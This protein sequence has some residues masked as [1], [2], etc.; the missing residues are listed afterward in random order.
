M[1]HHPQLYATRRNGCWSTCSCGWHSVILYTSVTGAHIAFGQHLVRLVQDKSWERYADFYNGH[2]HGEGPHACSTENC[3]GEGK[4]HYNS[5]GC[6]PCV[7][8][9]D[10]CD[11]KI[12]NGTDD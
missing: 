10:E 5:L 7:W 8:A 2:G 11:E 6:G 1:S 3:T 12:M 4:W 9:C